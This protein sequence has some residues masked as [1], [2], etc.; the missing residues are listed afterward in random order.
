MGRGLTVKG[1]R[2]ESWAVGGGHVLYFD[3]DGDYMIVYK[4]PKL[5]KL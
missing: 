2:R 1:Q 3:R 4:C 5:I